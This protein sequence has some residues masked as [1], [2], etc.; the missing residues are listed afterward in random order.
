MPATSLPNAGVRFPPP[1][2][3]V[4]GFVAG[5]AIG[6]FIF[7]LPLTRDHGSGLA[8]AGWWV[9]A[10]GVCLL[11]W[12][13]LTFVAMHTA[14]I[15]D[16][17]ASRVVTRGPYRFTRNPMYVGLSIVYL[18]LCAV[19]NSLWPVLVLPVVLTLL[20]RLVIRREEAYLLDA[21]GTDYA[22]YQAHVRRWL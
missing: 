19:V 9:V 3:F 14:I 6:R 17:P 5:W 15:P 22:Q 16:R 10:A 7:S 1:F 8:S 20:V 13:M 18:G 21:F 2:I 4:G 12:G 11:A